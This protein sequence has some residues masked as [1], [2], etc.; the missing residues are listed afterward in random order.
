VKFRLK[1]EAATP[2]LGADL[3]HMVAEIS[4]LNFWAAALESA[5]AARLCV[6]ILRLMWHFQSLLKTR[7]ARFLAS[8]RRF[9]PG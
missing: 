3:K 9:R 5:R 2:V 8:L 4:A 6:E 1:I 7:C